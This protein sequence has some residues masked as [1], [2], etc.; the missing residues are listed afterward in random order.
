VVDAQG[1]RK[2]GLASTVVF[3]KENGGQKSQVKK[4]HEAVLEKKGGSVNG[5]RLSEDECL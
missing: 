3:W 2:C 4:I 1:G 5:T